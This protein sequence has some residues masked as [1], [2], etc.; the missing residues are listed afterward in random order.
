MSNVYVNTEAMASWKVEMDK[1]NKACVD[2][3]DIIVNSMNELNSS[4]QGE[5]ADKYE[6]AFGQY[7][8]KVKNSHESMRDIEN[9]LD[10]VVN[11]MQSQ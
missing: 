2:N 5:Y 6:E 9:F 8:K 11:V 10:T 3:I 1:I 4:F 7:S